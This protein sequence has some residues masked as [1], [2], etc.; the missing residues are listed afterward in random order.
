MTDREQ[1]VQKMARAIFST[2][3]LGEN[4]TVESLNRYW[5]QKIPN[6]EVYKNCTKQAKA[7]LAAIEA[8]GL[9]LGEVVPCR[10]CDG[11]GVFLSEG[12]LAGEFECSTC[13]GTGK[14]FKPIK[15]GKV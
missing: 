8:E 11:A 14:G 3:N 13:R 9:V 2:P 6:D 7:A 4:Q 1:I 15:A 12:F 10:S 5:D